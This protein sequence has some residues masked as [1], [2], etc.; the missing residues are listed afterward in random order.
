MFSDM[1]IKPGED[2]ALEGPCDLVPT[3][4]PFVEIISHSN[5]LQVRGSCSHVT[6]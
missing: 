3:E 6:Y 5:C 1:Y 2:S 4:D